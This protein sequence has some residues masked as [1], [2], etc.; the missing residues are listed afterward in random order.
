M[1]GNKYY[2]NIIRVTQNLNKSNYYAQNEKNNTLI[3][4]NCILQIK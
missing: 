3:H 4:N 2:L 1:I